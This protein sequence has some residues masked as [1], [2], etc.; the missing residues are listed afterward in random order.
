M[1]NLDTH[2]LVFALTGEVTP[3]ERRVLQANRWGISAIVFWELA[4]L[5]ELRRL[6]LELGDTEVTRTLAS[7]QVWPID[8]AISRQSTA[9]DFSGDPA[10]ELIAAT[11]VVYSVPLLTRDRRIRRSR[12]VPFA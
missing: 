12:V 2:L 11:S 8:L 5:V 6:G 1:I 9:L 4:K 3:R 7:L 10:D